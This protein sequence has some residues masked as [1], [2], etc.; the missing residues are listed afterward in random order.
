MNSQNRISCCFVQFESDTASV[1]S[2]ARSD[3]FDGPAGAAFRGEQNAPLL[4]P[5]K[6]Y[7]GEAYF[8]SRAA[9]SKSRRASDLPEAKLQ[10]PGGRK[11]GDRKI[12]FCYNFPSWSNIEIN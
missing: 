1:R 3:V 11:T 7:R 8:S 2:A 6:H 9:P 10:R 5:P 12:S 4:L